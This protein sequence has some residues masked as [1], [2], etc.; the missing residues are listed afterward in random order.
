M[1]D[2]WV[3]GL[4][5]GAVTHKRVKPRRHALRYRMFW[6]LFD[7]DELDR[8]D[9]GL[10]LFSRNRFN[11]FSFRDRDHLEG[12]ARPLRQQ[13]EGYLTDAGLAPDGGPIRLLCVPRLLGY[14]FNPLSVYLCHRRDG[15][16]SAM[17]YEVNNTIGQRHSYLIPVEADTAGTVCQT[18]DKRFYVSPFM[19]M[20]LTY[21]FEVQPPG[22]HV[23]VAVTASD[24]Q[25]LVIATCF[26][27]EHRPLSD[28]ALV[29]TFAAH[30]LLAMKIVAGI[31]WEALRI[32]RK[33]IA[34]R[35]PPPRPATPVTLGRSEPR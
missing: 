10:R 3:S 31:H 35:S 30:P 21:R 5:D 33:G 19:D 16:L 15:T 34:F 20:D 22:A 32:W 23:S 7:L 24:A 2:V 9:R 25:G 26:S 13:I 6:M 17:L 11:L 4:Y 28:A 29:K 1:A 14:A 18:C 27:G 8:L 12:N